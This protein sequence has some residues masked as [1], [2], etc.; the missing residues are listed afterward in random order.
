MVARIEP[1]RVPAGEAAVV[2]VELQG[3]GNVKAL[4]PPE[5][6]RIPS[7]EVYPPSE[8][9][10][11]N[12][13]AAGVRGWKRFSWVVVPREAGEVRLPGLEYPVF[14]PV[15]GEYQMLQAQLP[16]IQVD[17]GAS[18]GAAAQGSGIRYLKTGPGAGS[19][20]AWVRSTGFAAAQALPL[21]L[22]A[23]ALVARRARKPE[24]KLSRR[25]LRRRRRAGVRELQS[26]AGNGGLEFLARAEAFAADWVSARTGIHPRDAGQP[27]A[28]VGA[29]L[30]R[31][32]AMRLRHV[33]DRLAAARFAP[34]PPDPE[35]RAALVRSLERVLEQIDREAPPLRRASARPAAAGAVLLLVLASADAAFAQPLDPDPAGRQADFASGVTHFDAGRYDEAA[36]AFQRHLLSNGTDAAGW[37]NLA[38]AYYRAGEPGRAVWAWLHSARLQPRDRDTR[39]NLRVAGAT[40]ELVSRATPPLALRPEELL[41]LAALAWFTA[42]AA[43]A[44]FILSR[45]PASAIPAAAAVVL[46]LVLAGLAFQASRG[47]G[48]LVALEAVQIRAGPNLQ[49]ETVADLAP[50]AGLAPVARRGPWARV[51]TLHGVDGWVDRSLVGHVPPP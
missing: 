37:Y 15:T 42:G 51:R 44:R 36:R 2:T 8:E 23:G 7:L 10:E 17:P 25:A 33:M 21:L 20:L 5:L 47:P 1:E 43:A 48:T 45:Q 22:V 50:G 3:A 31:E 18:N 30:P 46:A 28:L 11:L 6:P 19:R 24:R 32:T 14:D 34:V 29:G 35:T 49:A 13:S 39:H 40:P 16:P 9:A 41:L 38:T 27:D 4:P 26:M 12:V